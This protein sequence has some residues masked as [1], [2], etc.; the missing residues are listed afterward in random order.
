MSLSTKQALSPYKTISEVSEVT[1]VPHHVLRFW[2][3]KFDEIAPKKRRGHRYY[4]QKDVEVISAI[5]HLL[6]EKRY[7]IEGAKQHLKDLKK[8]KNVSRPN[9]ANDHIND[10]S[11]LEEVEEG[12]LEAK[13]PV[14]VNGVLNSVLSGA[15][16][17]KQDKSL[18]NQISSL[19]EEINEI[20]AL[21]KS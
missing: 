10:S 14:V 7:T 15:G 11:F 12:P 13:K 2:E 18:S 21:L 8:S 6:Y 17:I 1:G 9:F 3:K 20:K 16:H 5:K 4:Q 19:I